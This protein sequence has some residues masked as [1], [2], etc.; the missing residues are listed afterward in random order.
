MSM[1]AAPGL[2]LGQSECPAVRH[3]ARVPC[4][5]SLG[6]SALQYGTGP[7]CPAVRHWARV[8]ALQYGTGPECPAVRHWARVSALQYVTG[9]ECPAVRHWARVSALQYVTGPESV[10]CSTSL[11]QSQCPAVRWVLP[12][13]TTPLARAPAKLRRAVQQPCSLAVVRAGFVVLRGTRVALAATLLVARC[14]A[15]ARRQRP[16]GP[17]TPAGCSQVLAHDYGA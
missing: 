3:W 4:S 17:S 12:P 6:Q 5:T 7:E 10:P 9:P 1:R 11:G 8:S 16:V 2:C 15:C 14:V 13:C